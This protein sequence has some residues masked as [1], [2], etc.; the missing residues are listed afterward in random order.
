MKFQYL[1]TSAAEG[2]PAIF[3]NCEN[4]TRSRKLGGRN[5]RTR[6]QAII[7]DSLLID[8]P[9]DT[10]MH[11]LRFNFPLHQVKSCII[12]HSHDDHLYERDII[13]RKTGFAHIEPNQPITFYAAQSGYDMIKKVTDAYD[14]PESDVKCVK[15]LPF[16][17]MDIDGYSVTA[18]PAT[19]AED[20]SPVLYIIEKDEKSIFYS[21]DTAIYKNE[22]YEYLKNR[23][24]PFSMISLDCDEGC[25]EHISQSHLSL[26]QC[27]ELKKKFETD[28]ICDK[29]TVFVLNHFS[30][31]AKNVVY[32]D[33]SKIAEEYGFLTSYD[34]MIINI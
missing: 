34:G 6:S 26:W 21:H 32:E 5:I 23:Q 12:T 17:K 9:A 29:N 7:D 24:T 31:N 28:G 20:T 30:H 13:M 33:F 14:M 22:T 19:H 2:V 15:V 16:E 8:F 11:Y 4:C 3:C 10:Y 27:I 18:L 1:G 25:L